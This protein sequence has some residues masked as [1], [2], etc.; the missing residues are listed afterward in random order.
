MPRPVFGDKKTIESVD[1]FRVVL[2]EGVNVPVEVMRCRFCGAAVRVSFDDTWV[3][4]DDFG[5]GT[6]EFNCDAE[7]IIEDVGKREWNQWFRDHT[8][9]Y[10]S[11]QFEDENKFV[12]W[13]NNQYPTFKNY[14]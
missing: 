8:Y 7:P 3:D 4:G 10:P 14:C 1:P 5:A 11:E 12:K 6:I 2:R 13:F 9:R